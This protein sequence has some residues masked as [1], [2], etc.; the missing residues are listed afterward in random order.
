M[1]HVILL[2]ALSTVLCLPVSAAAQD[3]TKGRAVFPGHV[4]PI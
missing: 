1:R 4:P 2:A 3:T